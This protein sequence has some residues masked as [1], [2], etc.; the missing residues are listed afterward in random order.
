[1]DILTLQAPIKYYW[2]NLDELCNITKERCELFLEICY[3]QNEIHNITT[4]GNMD[5]LLVIHH[6]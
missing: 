4:L 5:H 1:M 6:A 2:N 3:I